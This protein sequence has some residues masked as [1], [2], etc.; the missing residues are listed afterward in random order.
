MCAG[1]VVVFLIPLEQMTEVPLAEYG[2]MVKA[3]PGLIRSA[4]PHIGSAMVGASTRYS[5]IFA[6]SHVPTIHPVMAWSSRQPRC[7][8]M[9]TPFGMRPTATPPAPQA[10]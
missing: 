10:D 7:N 2:D 4:F 6:T 3:I 5:G 8:G 9:I 1:L